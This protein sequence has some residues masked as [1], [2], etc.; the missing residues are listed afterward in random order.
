MSFL[1]N[2]WLNTRGGQVVEY[3]LIGG[4]IVILLLSA[5]NAIG[6]STKAMYDNLDSKWDAASG[7]GDGGDG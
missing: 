5:L 2:F 1:Q 3:A 6:S 4:L 7:G